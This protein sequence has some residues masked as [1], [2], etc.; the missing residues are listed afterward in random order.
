MSRSSTIEVWHATASADQPGPIESQ[1]ERWLAS[2]EIERANRF[3]RATSRNQH[4]IGRGMAKRL[5]GGG[6]VSPEEIQ[7]QV[8]D[9]GKP[10]VSSPN[11]LQQPFNIAHTEGLVLC[12]VAESRHELVGVDVERLDRRT[13]PEL[14]E[15]YFSKPE[16][17]YLSVINNKLDRQRAFLRI[18][19]LK[20]SFIKAIGTG[21][22]TPLA[23]FAF[24]DIESN[25]PQLRILNDQLVDGRV[26]QFFSI[27]PRSDFIGALAV[28]TDVDVSV[29]LKSFDDLIDQEA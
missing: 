11:A 23:D 18:W 19:T 27:V 17:E 26:W 2:S 7:F 3:R 8:E 4:V 9:H 28:A 1:C 15:R 16:V 13:D 21:L 6:R 25:T 12:S 5:L 29:Q 10:Y 24:V 20:E 22:Q 14:A